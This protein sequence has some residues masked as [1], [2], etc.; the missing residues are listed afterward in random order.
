MRHWDKSSGLTKNLATPRKT[1]KALGMTTI[2][3]LHAIHFDVRIGLGGVL[4]NLGGET[5]D[6][7]VSREDPM[8]RCPTYLVRDKQTG[9]LLC[10]FLPHHLYMQIEGVP[11]L[12]GI[13]GATPAGADATLIVPTH[14][15]LE[16]DCSDTGELA[17]CLPA[18]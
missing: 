8:S 12:F 11:T 7:V 2:I 3:G 6:C 18:D 10:S 5:Y 9:Q 14:G 17:D 1:E 4:L 13:E 16:K 15:M